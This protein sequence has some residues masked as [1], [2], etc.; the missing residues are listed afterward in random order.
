MN[1]IVITT[2]ILLYSL[3]NVP[4][5]SLATSSSDHRSGQ[6]PGRHSVSVSMTKSEPRIK[7]HRKTSSSASS[8]SSF[9]PLLAAE[10]SSADVSTA[11][12]GDGTSRPKVTLTVSSGNKSSSFECP[13]QFGYF[14]DLSDCS[15]YFV[16]VF[17]EALHETCTGG[18][19][20]SAELQTCD[21]PRN[22]HCDHDATSSQKN[23]SSSAPSSAP[24]TG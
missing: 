17:G 16:C 7:Y 9:S 10:S 4:K 8:A 23:V 5:R 3:I 15:K 18:L 13:E 2:T 1:L 20:F 19:Y 22:V 11:P 14:D 24:S 12:E 21:W 6:P